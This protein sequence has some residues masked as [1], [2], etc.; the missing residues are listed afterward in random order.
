MKDIHLCALYGI[1]AT[2][3]NITSKTLI[4]NYSVNPSFIILLIQHIIIVIYGLTKHYIISWSEAQECILISLYSLGNI[5]FGG[6]GM[7]YVN[8]PMYITLR[9][10]CTAEIFIIDTIFYKQPYKYSCVIG[11]AGISLGALIAGY[12]DLTSD[13][14]GFIIVFLA[15]LMNALLL[16]QIRYAKERVFSLKSFKQVYICSLISIP[17][18]IILYF[19]AE[20]YV[21]VGLSPYSHTWELYFAIVFA[22]VLGVFCNFLLFKC[23][24]EISP[25]A[26]S[27][28]GNAKDFISMLIGLV[29][30]KDV[31]P[32]FLFMFGIFV[33]FLGAM[34]YSVGKVVNNKKI[35][36]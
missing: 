16:L 21:S 9:K 30:F 11:V 34:I 4:A 1:A 13:A 12:N 27:V 32:N 36:V 35:S 18:T 28:T 22:G 6:I 23:A 24:N 19:T 14:F 29:A 5:V 2:M 7:R 25:M 31:N 20:E 8:L 10:L 26:T 17:Y 15:N 3:M 33:S